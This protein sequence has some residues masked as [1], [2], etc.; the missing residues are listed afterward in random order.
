MSD[1][2]PRRSHFL[3]RTR[4]G[5]TATI[6]FLA[7]FLLAMPPVT[8]TVL[9]RTDPSVFGLPFFYVALLVVY[10]ALILVLVWAFRRG[11]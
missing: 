7:L 2:S 9:N 1:D 10:T 4:D 5:R 11:V 6:A 3:P 8:H